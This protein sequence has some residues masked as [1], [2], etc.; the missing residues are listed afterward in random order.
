MSNEEILRKAIEKAVGNKLFMEGGF[1]RKL[2]IE[3]PY[4]QVWWT[5]DRKHDMETPKWKFIFSHSFAKAFWGDGRICYKVGNLTNYQFD[6]FVTAIP[7][8]QHH[9][10]TMV[11]EKEPLLYLSRFL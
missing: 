2:E 3:E 6:K 5:N 8:W 11:L 4:I 9:L 1:V 7:R 10:Q